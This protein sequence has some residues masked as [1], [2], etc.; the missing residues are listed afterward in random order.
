MKPFIFALF[1]ALSICSVTV[2]DVSSVAAE[3]SAGGE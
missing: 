1:L 3:G 2:V